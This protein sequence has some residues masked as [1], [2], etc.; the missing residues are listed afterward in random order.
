MADAL[1][2]VCHHRE[3]ENTEKAQLVKFNYAQADRPVNSP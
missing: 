2:E 1:A 3:T